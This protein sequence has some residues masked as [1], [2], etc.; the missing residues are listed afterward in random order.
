MSLNYRRNF[1]FILLYVIIGVVFGVFLVANLDLSKQVKAEKEIKES[2]SG[3]GST[4]LGKIQES[5][6]KIAEEVGSAV[7]SISTVSTRRVGVG[8]DF[9]E[10]PFGRDDFFDRFFRDFFGDLPEREYKQMGLG[11]GV[12]IDKKGYIL[13]NEHVVK[14]ADDITVTLPDGREFKGEILGTDPRSD[15][16]V[17]KIDADNLP[18]AK[19][20]DSDKLR[21]GEWSVAI[22]NPFGFYLKSSIPTVTVGVI[23]AL[24]RHLPMTSY[25]SRLYTDLIQTDAAINP[26]NSGGPLVNLKGEVIGIN[27]AIMSSTGGYQGIGFAIPINTAKFRLDNLIK[28]IEVEY[29][30]LGVSV[31]DITKDLADYFRLEDRKGVLVAKVFKNSPADKA[32]VKEGDIIKEFDGKKIEDVRGLINIVSCTKVGKRVKVLIIRDNK[33]LTLTVKVGKRPEDIS[34]LT[35][36]T[37]G[38]WNGMTVADI[39]SDLSSKYNIPAGEGVVVTEVE[40]GSVASLAGI[41]VGDIILSINRKPI[42]SVKDFNR[43]TKDIKKGESV[44]IHTDR[45]YIII[46]TND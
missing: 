29:G 40:R 37:S 14:D 16:A 23:S 9:F 46:K 28:G 38:K 27:V 13:T 10:F 20:G 36:S 25:R 19:L 35:E 33:P 44:L 24:H 1:I 45:G 22:G 5:F 15:L 12:I 3:V 32:G 31:Q 11:S 6:I 26:G 8:G 42:N 34:A 30:W 7:V 2:V 4:E 43:V 18:V 21:I 39:T 41:R 17:I